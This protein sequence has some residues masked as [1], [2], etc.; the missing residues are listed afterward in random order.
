MFALKKQDLPSRGIFYPNTP[1]DITIKPFGIDELMDV[2]SAIESK[3]DDPLIRAVTKSTTIVDPI[4][5]G[6][7]YFILACIRVLTYTKLP[8]KWDYVCRSV[9]LTITFNENADEVG[10]E[11]FA[12]RFGFKQISPSVYTRANISTEESAQV[13]D[14]LRVDMPNS[15]QGTFGYCNTP[16]SSNV[17]T[18]LLLSNI[19]R[20]SSEITEDSIPQNF[21][22]PTVDTLAEYKQ[23][24]ADAKLRKLLPMLAC[25]GTGSIS[26]VLSNLRQNADSVEKLE[27][28]AELS[29]RL[30]HGIANKLLCR[31]CKEC[32]A[33]TDEQDFVISA[34]S[35]FQK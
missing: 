16:D 29:R 12:S 28:A 24:Y 17:D 4:T 11:L 2:S 19:V 10:I 9:R 14:H 34:E 1:D 25:I 22:V 26:H 5:Y 23:L 8:I 7:F 35:F 30:Q 3:S 33:R 32:G 15:Y 21:R 31:E 20:L 6:D 18:D 13:I 27:K